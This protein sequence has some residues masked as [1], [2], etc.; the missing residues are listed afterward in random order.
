MNDLFNRRNASSD[1]NAK[2]HHSESAKLAGEVPTKYPLDDGPLT[3]KQ[4]VAIR[5]AAGNAEQGKLKSSL[6]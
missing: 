5:K 4:L 6:F 3:R 1:A 2:R